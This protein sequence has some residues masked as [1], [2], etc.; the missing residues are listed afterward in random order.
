[1]RK[2]LI[3]TLFILTMTTLMVSLVNAAEI[4]LMYWGMSASSEQQ[5]RAIIDEF[6]RRY[7]G[8]IKV[9]PGFTMSTEELREKLAVALAA[10]AA[11]D[12]VRFDRFAIPEWAYQGLFKPIDHL[13]E[14]DAID[15]S[16]FYPAAWN[17][18]IFEGKT[19]GIPHNMDVRALLYNKTVYEESGL[20]PAVSP[21]TWDDLATF[22]RKLDRKDG[23]QFTRIGFNPIHGNWYYYGYLLMAGG[24]LFDSTNRQVAWNSDAGRLA[25]NYM[26]DWIGY[27]GG[28]TEI[29]RVRSGGTYPS[30]ADGRVVS[31]LGGSWFVGSIL[32]VNPNT[33]IGVGIPPRPTELADEIISWSGGFAMVIP[34]TTPLSKEEAVWEFIKFFT[35][36]EAMIM[37]FRDN[38]LGQLPPRRSVMQ[39]PEFQATQPPQLLD[40]LAILPHSRFRP[41]IPGGE[42]LWKIYRDQL[43]A[44][45]LA[46]VVPDQAVAETARLGQIA[47]DEAWRAVK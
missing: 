1:M 41:V 46:G 27:Y 16:D 9:D 22:A 2:G 31:I 35:G 5:E 30:F 7:A 15:I 25:A 45:I 38:S 17:E 13:I 4:Q 32:N 12:V 44:L 28:Q 34:T 11:P 8:Q 24:D 21:R 42:T 37:A 6:N 14:R 26:A 39:D 40:F 3:G 43:E 18:L 10:G 36:Q 19:Y 47:L 33:D 29:S 23:G 20:D